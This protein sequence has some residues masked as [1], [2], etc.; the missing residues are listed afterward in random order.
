[1]EQHQIAS[2][3]IVL[4][5]LYGSRTMWDILMVVYWGCVAMP[6]AILCAGVVTAFRDA[7]AWQSDSLY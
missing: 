4:L 7:S 2:Q 1:M 5:A 3:A 6:V